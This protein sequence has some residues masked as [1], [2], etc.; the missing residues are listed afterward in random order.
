VVGISGR[1]TPD[2][3]IHLCAQ[4]ASLIPTPAANRPKWSSPAGE[5]RIKTPV[6]VITAT[7]RPSGETEKA[8]ELYRWFRTGGGLTPLINDANPGAFPGLEVLH[9]FVKHSDFHNLN[10]CAGSR[11]RRSE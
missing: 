11:G 3:S 5:H 2:G 7:L 10:S 6:G 9:S 8:A 4:S 1:L